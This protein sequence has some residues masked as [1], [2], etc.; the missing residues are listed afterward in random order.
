MKRFLLTAAA[1]CGLCVGAMAVRAADD[2][3]EGKEVKGVLIDNNCGAKQA[4]EEAAANHPKTCAMKEGCAKSGYAV[5][6]G[7][8]LIKFDEKGNAK[9]KEY[10]AVAENATKVIVI[11]TL[12][13][14]GKTIT[15]TDIKPQA[16]KDEK[17]A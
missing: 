11:G 2:A 3:A 13:E 12:S 14:D 4:S 10:L 17:G 5:M 9:A 1:V 15:V 6:S 8:K 7:K 16:K